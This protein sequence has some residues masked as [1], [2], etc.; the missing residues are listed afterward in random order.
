MSST[1]QMTEVYV[2][3]IN[4]IDWS[5]VPDILAKEQVQ[6]ISGLALG[7]DAAAHPEADRSA[8]FGKRRQIWHGEKARTEN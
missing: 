2:M 3:K 7:I 5:K 8:D 1:E 4:D 6:I